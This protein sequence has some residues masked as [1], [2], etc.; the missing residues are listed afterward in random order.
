MPDKRKFPLISGIAGGTMKKRGFTMVELI[1]VVAVIAILASIIIPKMSGARDKAKLAGCKTN[2]K[3]I[4][5]AFELYAN[6]NQ[7]C[8]QPSDYATLD[9]SHSLVAGNYLKRTP[10]CPGA[11]SQETYSY[12]VNSQEATLPAHR[13]YLIYCRATPSRHA[14]LGLDANRPAYHSAKGIIENGAIVQ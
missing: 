5:I 3:H 10:M 8:Y 11:G 9:S 12:Y 2:M 4:S 6:D 7:G 14:A 13:W 1:I